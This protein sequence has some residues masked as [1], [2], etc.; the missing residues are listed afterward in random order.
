MTLICRS[1]E[2]SFIV[3]SDSMSSLEALSGFKIELYL[4]YGI[5]KD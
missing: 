1:K 5:I 2:K 3:F 4:L